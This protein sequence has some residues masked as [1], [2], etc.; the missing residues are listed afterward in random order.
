MT[1]TPDMM[2]ISDHDCSNTQIIVEHFNCFSATVD[3][4]ILNVMIIT[5]ITG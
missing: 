2:T 5:V 1:P 3:D 4:E